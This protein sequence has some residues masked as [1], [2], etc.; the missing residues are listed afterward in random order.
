MKKKLDHAAILQDLETMTVVNIAEKH[1][2][3]RVRVYYIRRMAEG[4]K[5]KQKEIIERRKKENIMKPITKKEIKEF[6]GTRKNF[7]GW[8]LGKE[9][10]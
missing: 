5:P 7:T 9:A 3:S 8:I 2:C 10:D 1:N 4:Y 6:L